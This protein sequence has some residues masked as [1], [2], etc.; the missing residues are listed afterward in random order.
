MKSLLCAMAVAFLMC[1]TTTSA[2]AT[3]TV[4][5]AN[6]CWLALN[7]RALSAGLSLPLDQQGR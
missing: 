5:S 2:K 6:L 3:L 7:S 1:M 4:P